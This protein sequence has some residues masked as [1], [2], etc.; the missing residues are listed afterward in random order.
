MSVMQKD[1]AH[2]SIITFIVASTFI[3]NLL[4]LLRPCP[5][6][7]SSRFVILMLICRPLS[8]AEESWRGEEAEAEENWLD[9]KNVSVLIQSNF[10]WRTLWVFVSAQMK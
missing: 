8:V 1:L 7:R 10:E 9:E 5:V 6:C 3:R 4:I 2:W